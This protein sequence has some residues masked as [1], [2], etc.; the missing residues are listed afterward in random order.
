MRSCYLHGRKR[1]FLR[2]NRHCGQKQWGCGLGA[3]INFAGLGA[4]K[5]E[6][7]GVG[8][9]A[10]SAQ[11]RDLKQMKRRQ[12]TSAT[13]LQYPE[14]YTASSAIASALYAILAILAMTCIVLNGDKIYSHTRL[15][16]QRTPITSRIPWPESW[17]PKHR[18]SGM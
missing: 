10:L 11:H 1:K 2:G 17:P 15:R 3:A 4:G 8:A 18:G 5:D 16:L 6:S 13:A 12:R 7:P 9:T 14:I